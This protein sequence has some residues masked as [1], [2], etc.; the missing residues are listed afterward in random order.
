MKEEE[1][2]KD[3]ESKVNDVPLEK[4]KLSEI[5]G[6][7]ELLEC[8]SLFDNSGGKIRQSLSVISKRIGKLSLETKKQSKMLDF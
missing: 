1:E 4:S 2:E 7:I 8:Y 6:A 5:A 3:A